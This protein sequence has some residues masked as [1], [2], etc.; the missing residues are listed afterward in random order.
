MASNTDDNENHWPGYVDALTT[1]TMVLTFVM[2]V[3]GIAIFTLSQN[4]SR[5][6]LDAIARAVNVSANPDETSQEDMARQ[7]IA[8]IEAIAAENQAKPAAPAEPAKQGAPGQSPTPGETIASL[9]EAT[10]EQ[11]LA[12]VRLEGDARALRVVFKPRA[13]TLDEAARSQLA[14]RLKALPPEAATGIIEIRA[15]IDPSNAAVSDARRVAFYRAMRARSEVMQTGIA[16]ARIHVIVD[17]QTPG[18]DVVVSV[19]P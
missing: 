4:V 13:T 11:R 2:M 6:F 8:R 17:P 3:L 10:T 9:S 5:G 1:M 18:D 15:G 7:V 12:P 16:A 14:E 19:R